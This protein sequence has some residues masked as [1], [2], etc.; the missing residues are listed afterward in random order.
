M[1]FGAPSSPHPRPQGRRSR[2]RRFVPLALAAW[3]VLEIWLLV[4]VADATNALTVLALLVAGGLL[5]GY[6][7]KRA[8]RRAW[9]TLTAGLRPGAGTTDED[10]T[11]GLGNG[12]LMLGG[13]L[14]MLPGLASD[15]L[16]LVLLFPPTRTLLGRGA[17]RALSRRMGYATSS[18]GDAFQQA[19]RDRVHRTGGGKV[20]PGEVVRDDEP[21][22]AGGPEDGRGPGRQ[23]PPLPR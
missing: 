3:L 19:G 12:L 16:A 13:L 10:S 9:Q 21:P 15:A 5:G 6:V 2:A 20:V 17:E 7:I 8:G 23:D 11:A 18:L 22:T 14:L 1:T 4:L